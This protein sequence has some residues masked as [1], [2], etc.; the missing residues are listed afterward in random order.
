[1]PDKAKIKIEKGLMVM[2]AKK[3]TFDMQDIVNRRFMYHPQTA[4]LIL[5]PQYKDGNFIVG[6]HAEEHGNSGIKLPFDEF[7]RGWVGTGRS[8]KNGVIHFAPDISHL[9]PKE[10]EK[11][12]D[13]LVMFKENNANAQTVVR[14][15]GKLWEQP[16]SKAME[17]G[18]EAPAPEPEKKPSV[19]KRLKDGQPKQEARPKKPA[20]SSR[21]L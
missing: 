4:T 14:G 17:A 16:L 6:S 21:E 1:M 15:F 18:R 5:G 11:G 2:D 10:F 19:R 12:F 20:R 9:Y 8:Y 7:T 13:T 3:Q